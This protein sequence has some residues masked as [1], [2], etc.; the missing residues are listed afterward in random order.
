LRG[1]LVLTCDFGA[2][3]LPLDSYRQRT[4]RQ[5][6][7]PTLAT[8]SRLRLLHVILPSTLPVGAGG[9]DLP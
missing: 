3:Q 7:S 8:G 5:L 9:S 2:P 6:F 4:R 1:G